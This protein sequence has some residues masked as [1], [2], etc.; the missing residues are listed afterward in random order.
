MSDQNHIKKPAIP[1]P[2]HELMKQLV[3]ADGA[4]VRAAIVV[5]ISFDG[6]VCSSSV[7]VGMEEQASDLLTRE[8]SAIITQPIIDFLRDRCGVSTARCGCRV[9]ESRRNDIAITPSMGGPKAEA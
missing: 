8:L 4:R 9:C 2:A 1:M 5:R 6:A 3:E 7:T